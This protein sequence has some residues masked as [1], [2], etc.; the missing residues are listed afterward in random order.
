MVCERVNACFTC[1]G[2][3]TLAAKK[4]A[5]RDGDE[6]HSR[7]G[8]VW[9]RKYQAPKIS[10]TKSKYTWYWV[11]SKGGLPWGLAG[12]GMDAGGYEGWCFRKWDWTE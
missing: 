9:Y 11:S 2:G 3:C 10:R 5:T 6:V 1:G 12:G 7:G 4:V 8:D